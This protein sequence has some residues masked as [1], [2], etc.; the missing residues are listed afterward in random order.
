MLYLALK[1]HRTL[2][3]IAISNCILLHIQNERKWNESMLEEQIALADNHKAEEK[4][5]EECQDHYGVQLDK[6]HSFDIR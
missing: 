4:N 3:P 1:Q 5:Q 2:L 6:I